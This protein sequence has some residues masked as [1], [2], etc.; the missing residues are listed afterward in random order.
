MRLL[1]DLFSPGP[2]PSKLAVL[3]ENNQLCHALDQS[4]FLEDA[5]FTVLDTELTGLSARKEEIVSLGAV[6]LHGLTLVPGKSYSALVRPSIPLPKVSTLIHRIT[7]ATVCAAPPLVEVLPEFVEFCKG[8][9][10]IGHHIG[11]D[12]KFINRACRIFFGQSMRNP[13]L[14]TLRLAMIWR[15]KQAA[16]HYERFN[17]NISYT[18]SD[19]ATEFELPRFTAHSALGDA[20]QTAYLFMYLVKKIART[21]PLT[22]RELFR[23]GQSWRWYW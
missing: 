14:D 2:R 11:L 5:V 8:T 1:R 15:E 3:D 19:L 21:T 22:L 10:I 9:L 4:L 20:L 6:R 13:C 16:S 23:T 7:P 12:M 18:L 17:L